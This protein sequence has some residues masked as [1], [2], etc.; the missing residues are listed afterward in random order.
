MVMPSK[1]AYTQQALYGLRVPVRGTQSFVAVMARVWKRPALLALE[2]LWRWGV[3]IPLLWLVWRSLT[4]A[5]AGM[6]WDAGILERLTVFRLNESVALVAQQL[7]TVL[8]PLLHIL[9]WWA[10]LALALWSTGAA[11]GRTA[12]WRRLDP[13]LHPAYLLTVGMALARSLLLA[14]TY[15]LWAGV[16]LEALRFTLS[17]GA[18]PNIVLF[19]ALV[20]AL[21]LLLFMVWSLASWIFDIV[22]LFCMA[23]GLSFGGSLRTAWRSRALVSKLIE[24]N[25]VMGIVKVAL[26]V[27]AMVFSASPLPFSSVESSGFLA[28]WWSLVG[29]FFVAFLD[30]FHVIRRAAYLALLQVYS[31]GSDRPE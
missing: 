10:P 6:R 4:R 5:F 22:P 16:S 9:R 8:P 12:I 29:V 15:A 7:G 2:L 3:G 21:T 30:L 14:A 20:V 1:N 28:V 26:L 19:V 31:P 11:L 24:T 18:E 13:A 17:T 27:L 23:A 25:L